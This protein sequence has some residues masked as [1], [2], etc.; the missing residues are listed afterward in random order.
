MELRF[1]NHK[2]KFLDSLNFIPMPLK[3]FPKSFGVKEL[4]KGYFPHLFNTIGNQD[5]VGQMPDKNYFD[6]DSMPASERANFLKWYEENKH[7]QN[8]NLQAEMKAYCRSDV[9]ILHKCV[10]VFR[11]L[12]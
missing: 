3:K 8:Y 7:I 9:D 4:K 12:L 6:P 11:D 10:L 2:L 5:Y 1:P